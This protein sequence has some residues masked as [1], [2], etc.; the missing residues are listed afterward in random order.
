MIALLLMCNFRFSFF[1]ALLFLALCR[2]LLFSA[3][4]A[5]FVAQVSVQREK[6]NERT[7]F[8]YPKPPGGASQ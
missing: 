5:H 6:R 4:A 2:A 8:I 1:G 3:A 7:E